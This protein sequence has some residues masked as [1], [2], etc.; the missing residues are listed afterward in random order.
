MEGGGGCGVGCGGGGHV[1]G[2]GEEKVMDN[3]AY[4]FAWSL[5]TMCRDPLQKDRGRGDVFI[6]GCGGGGCLHEV[7][8][9]T[10]EKGE[11]KTAHE[12]NFTH[13]K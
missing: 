12:N 8:E 10:E 5:Y 3:F 9:V 7:H 4:S 11:F 6:E 1:H 2:V 13:P